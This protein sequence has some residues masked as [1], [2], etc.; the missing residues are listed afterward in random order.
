MVHYY[1]A[2]GTTGYRIRGVVPS[3][4]S[5]EG[6]VGECFNGLRYHH[7]PSAFFLSLSPF[8]RSR[9]RLYST[10]LETQ[11]FGRMGNKRRVCC[12]GRR[13]AGSTLH[14]SRLNHIVE[15]TWFPL[16]SVVIVSSTSSS[17]L[18]VCITSSSR[19]SA[20]TPIS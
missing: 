4:S 19:Y 7:V 12:C 1:S 10:V 8:I 2:R 3:H 9:V 5:S 16:L 20:T 14:P 18:S 6:R 15:C 17:P 11:G 13:D